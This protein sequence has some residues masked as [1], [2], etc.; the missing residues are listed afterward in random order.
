MDTGADGVTCAMGLPVQRPLSLQGVPRNV[1]TDYDRM[2]R[3]RA[4]CLVNRAI[5]SINLFNLI[6]TKVGADKP[7]RGQ[8]GDTGRRHGKMTFA[9][10]SWFSNFNLA[11][12]D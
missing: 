11:T 1:R 3:A 12:M 5:D 9:T 2:S 4:W 8:P 7:M 6:R 10:A